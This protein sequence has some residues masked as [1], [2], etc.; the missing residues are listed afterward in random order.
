[1]RGRE[2]APVLDSQLEPCRSPGDVRYLS[3]IDIR[4]SRTLKPQ[5]V[6][7]KA[8]EVQW[9]GKMIS[10][11]QLIRVK[12]ENATRICDARSRPGGTEKHAGGHSRPPKVHRFSEDTDLQPFDLTEIR[13]SR[14][15]VRSS[16]DHRYV[17]RRHRRASSLRRGCKTPCIFRVRRGSVEA[18]RKG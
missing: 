6:V 16:T 1:M 2:S 5:A 11:G 14:K 3:L 18:P 12:A 13:A 15:T 8:P 17:I 4:N 10:A 7:N 9:G